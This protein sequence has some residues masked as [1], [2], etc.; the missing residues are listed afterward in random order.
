MTDEPNYILW[1]EDDLV[2]NAHLRTNLLAWPPLRLRQAV[3]A[4]LY[5]PGL[6]ETAWDLKADARLVKPVDFYG[7]AALVMAADFLRRLLDG[8]FEASSALDAKLVALAASEGR[9]IYVHNPSLVQRPRR[10][11]GRRSAVH[12]AED[13]TRLG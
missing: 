3:A 5:N 13:Y 1:F 7:A 12:K 9:S 11:A 10:P 8:W 6:T 2:F 4:T